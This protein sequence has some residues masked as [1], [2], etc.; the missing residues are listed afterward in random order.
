MIKI[1]SAKYDVD[2]KALT[3]L[4]FLLHFV[5]KETSKASYN[6]QFV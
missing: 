3:V 6:L 4:V 2:L 5:E 1:Y